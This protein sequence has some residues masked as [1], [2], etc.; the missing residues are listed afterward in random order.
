MS[1][2]Y[3]VMILCIF[4]L[5]GCVNEPRPMT[6][7]PEPV[8]YTANLDK[9]EYSDSVLDVSIVPAMS[10]NSGIKGYTSFI[11]TIKNKSNGDIKLSWNESYFLEK[12]EAR[13]GFMFEGVKYADREGAKPDALILSKSTLTRQIF[14]NIKVVH[15]PY[16]ASAKRFG[17]PTGWVNG[18]LSDGE[19]GAYLQFHG[20]KY[21]K[22]VRLLVDIQSQ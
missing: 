5:V 8:R 17:L 7:M 22:T 1:K 15:F 3:G 14:P 11:L 20:G 10:G 6:A 2:V 21:K 9:A 13:G 4:C 12:S 16:D 19:C 18:K